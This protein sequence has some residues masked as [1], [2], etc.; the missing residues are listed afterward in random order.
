MT[1]LLFSETEVAGYYEARLVKEKSLLKRRVKTG[2]IGRA[3]LH[4]IHHEFSKL[5][6]V[7]KPDEIRCDIQPHPILELY[8]FPYYDKTID[9]ILKSF[10]FYFHTNFGFLRTDNCSSLDELK[11]SNLLRMWVKNDHC[12]ELLRSFP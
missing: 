10:L 4:A 8:S 12:S 6:L 2:N 3:Q 5:F 11:V 1:P 7:L 9:V